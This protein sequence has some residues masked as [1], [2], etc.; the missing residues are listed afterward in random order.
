MAEPPFLVWEC[1]EC[2]YLRSDLEQRALRFPMPCP[3]CK[4]NDFRPGVSSSKTHPV[5]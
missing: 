3:C 2:G 5:P 1:S 4:R